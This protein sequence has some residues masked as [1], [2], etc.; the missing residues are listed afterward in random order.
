MIYL[1]VNE[2]GEITTEGTRIFNSILNNLK[3]SSTIQNAQIA[4]DDVKV[5]VKEAICAF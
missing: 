3:K 5:V 2:H 4:L 1:K